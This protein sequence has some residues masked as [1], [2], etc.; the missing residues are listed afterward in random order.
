MKKQFKNSFKA[1]IAVAL[2]ISF[3]GCEDLEKF[4]PVEAN[5]IAD[6]TPPEA[7][8]TSTQGTGTEE[9]WKD[10]TFA[11]GSISATS[12]AWD[13]GNGTTSTDVDGSATYPGEGMYTITLT[14]MDDLGVTSTFSETI[15]VVEPPAPLANIPDIAEPGFD[16][17]ND[18]RDAWRN[19]DLGG[20][21]QITGSGGFFEG[22]NGAKLPDPGSD[23]IGYQLLT[24]FT[25]NSDYVLT[26][27]YRMKNDQA[28]DGVLNVRMMTATSNPADIAAN[29]IASVS[30][31]EDATNL[32]AL[33][34]GT[35][36]F[37]SGSNTSLAIYFDN[38]LDEAYIDSFVLDIQ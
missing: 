35:L 34:T 21:I 17:G 23:R 16:Q 27:K 7:S 37:N 24:D 12:Y 31:T 30:F 18:S 15:D 10:Y 5:S 20:V 25:P 4:K 32:A 19:S 22:S 33:Q 8:F 2:V 26:F 3:Y 29:T 6:A 13:F 1:L 14:A 38:E 9:A 11:N 36:L 28:G